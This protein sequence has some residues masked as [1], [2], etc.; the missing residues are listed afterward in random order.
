MA[1]ALRFYKLSS[2]ELCVIHDDVDLALGTLKESTSSRSAGHRGVQDIIDHLGTQ[3]FYR[4]R[5]GVGRPAH[6]EHA[7]ADFVLENF[8]PE[9]ETTLRALFPEVA[10]ATSAFIRERST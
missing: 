6:P 5:L 7:T 2:Q 1:A 10:A 4:I 8:A 3:D 9:E